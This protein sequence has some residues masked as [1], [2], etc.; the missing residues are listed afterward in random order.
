M[1]IPTPATPA[2]PMPM[3]KL[4]AHT[5]AELIPWSVVASMSS[6]AALTAVPNRVLFRNEIDDQSR[7]QREP[8]KREAEPRHPQP[9]T[10]DHGA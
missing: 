7:H 4:M 1:A 2:R 3:A 9:P 10:G 6:E 8:Q 5:H